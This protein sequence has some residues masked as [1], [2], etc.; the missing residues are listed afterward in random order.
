MLF[1]SSNCFVFPSRFEGFSGALVEAMMTGVPIISS[2]IPM[3][4]EAVEHNKTALVHEMKNSK[5]LLSK[6]DFFEILPELR[7]YTF[8][9][10][11]F[12]RERNLLKEKIYSS[13]LH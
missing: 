1:R 4:L 2:N 7:R 9:R 5:D 11:Q 3:N 13:L 6:M 12:V 8:Q 10:P